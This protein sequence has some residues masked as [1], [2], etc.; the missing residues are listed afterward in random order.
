[1]VRVI[2][3]LLTELGVGVQAADGSILPMLGTRPS[4]GTGVADEGHNRF[5]IHWLGRVHL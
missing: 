3:C 1:M 2:P 4:L 5:Y